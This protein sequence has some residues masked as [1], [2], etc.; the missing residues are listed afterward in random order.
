MWGTAPAFPDSVSQSINESLAAGLYRRTHKKQTLIDMLRGPI[1]TKLV[2][3]DSPTDSTREHALQL[4]TWAADLLS[5][6]ALW[7]LGEHYL[8]GTHG[9]QPDIEKARQAYE[10]LA[11]T[12]NATAHARLG[13]LYSSRFMADMYGAPQSNAK[14]LEHYE[15]AASSGNWHAINALAFRLRYGIGLSQNCTRSLE[16]SDQVATQTYAQYLDGPPGGRTLPYSKVRL[17]DRAWFMLGEKPLLSERDMRVHMSPPA[18]VSHFPSGPINYRAALVQPD[19]MDTLLAHHTSKVDEQDAVKTLEYARYLYYGSILS[20]HDALGAI[21]PNHTLAAQLAYTLAVQR[22]PTPITIQD[23]DNPHEMRDKAASMLTTQPMPEE[24]AQIAASAAALLGLMYLRGEGV[25]QDAEIASIWLARASEAKDPLGMTSM[26]MMYLNGYGGPAKDEKKNRAY[27]HYVT[28]YLDIFHPELILAKSEL[29]KYEFRQNNTDKAH[30]LFKR[31]RNAIQLS[32]QMPG[33]YFLM[34]KFEPYYLSARL[35]VDKLYRERHYDGCPTWSIESFRV[36]AH[37][38][39]WSDPMYHRGE[40]AMDRG[41]VSTALRAWSIAAEAGME[42]AQDNI[43]YF[44]DP[45][46]HG[47]LSDSDQIFLHTESRRE[48]SSYVHHMGE[49]AHHYWTLSAKQESAY[50]RLMLCDYLKRHSPDDVQRVATCYK[51]IDSYH[52]RM[53]LAQWQIE[54]EHD[55]VLAKQANE[56][57]SPYVQ[58]GANPAWP[59]MASCLRLYVYALAAWALVKGDASAQH[60][61]GIHR[62]PLVSDVV[63]FTT[64]I[65]GLATLALVRR[66]LL[67][68]LRD[69]PRT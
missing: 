19:A 38:A 16:L 58:L 1:T 41:D 66:R 29:G 55:F 37:R 65:V 56:R 18:W 13:Y 42:E 61:F 45:Y 44:L 43:A 14:A 10:R 35:S 25:P 64:G 33:R 28:Q 31:A 34:S 22:W 52:A 15:L 51:A 60:L 8:W 63:L 11:L 17:S 39:D 20:D 40:A 69:M 5:S 21:H 62:I 23:N 48:P 30:L 54:R 59:Q 26:I 57:L 50:A 46:V 12:G 68:G 67:R 3:R 9:A 49:L 4:L 36:F 2:S 7:I 32:S 27:D 53:R 6:D 47:P 24:Q